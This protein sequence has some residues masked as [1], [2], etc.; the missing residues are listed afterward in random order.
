MEAFKRHY[1]SDLS[2]EEFFD[3]VYLDHLHGKIELGSL[4]D[5]I[6]HLDRIRRKFDTYSPSK[7]ADVSYS[8]KDIT[9]QYTRRMLDTQYLDNK[10]VKEEIRCL[11]K[12]LLQKNQILAE[13]LQASMLAQK[14]MEST[15]SELQDKVELL[16][17]TMSHEFRI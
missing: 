9:E 10:D 12:D 2:P 13:E 17:K 1:Q 3:V 11:T 15:L 8:I 14:K 5:C 4:G 16:K 6:Q 7:K